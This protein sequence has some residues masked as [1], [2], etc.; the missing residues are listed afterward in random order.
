MAYG[1]NYTNFDE[2]TE[3]RKPVLDLITIARAV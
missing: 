1:K 2:N 3:N